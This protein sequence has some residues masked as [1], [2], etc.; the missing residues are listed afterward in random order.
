[1]TLVVKPPHPQL[2]NIRVIGCDG[3]DVFHILGDRM[4]EEGVCVRAGGI[5]QLFEAP[6]R[7]L[8]RTPVRMDGGILRAVKTAIM[9]PILTVSVSSQHVNESF[10][11]VDGRFREAFSF[12]L[13]PYYG[14]SSLARIEWETETCTRWIDVV[15]TEGSTYDVTLDPHVPGFYL[16]TIHMKA[17]V[18][19]W[20]E[21]DV[22]TPLNFTTNG[23]KQIPISNPTGVPMAPK[24]IGTRA[25]WTIPDNT[26]TGKK[27][28]RIP[29][30][31]HPTRAIKYPNLTPLNGGIV[32]DY[33]L[34]DVPVRDAYDRNI[35]GQMPVPGDYPK[36]LIPPFT[37]QQMLNIT[38]A[39]VPAGG[40]TIQLR[41]PRM[42]RRPWGAT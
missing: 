19:F 8:E 3:G 27:W 37:Q 28:A 15:L 9:E 25:Q 1:M 22:V 33:G 7:I 36:N 21:N 6:I 11:V 26:W 31:A 23:T 30:G 4:G 41:Q 14:S 24:W 32:V 35:I 40:A 18:P 20:R 13:D 16:W 5:E 34:S 10:N 38:A 29:G 42:Y 17:Y 2:S 12:E 39:N